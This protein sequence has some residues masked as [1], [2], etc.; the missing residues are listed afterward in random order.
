M[1]FG[2]R[3]PSE[4]VRAF[5]TRLPRIRHQSVWPRPGKIPCSDSTRS[6][7]AICNLHLLKVVEV[8]TP[9][10]SDLAAF[11]HRHFWRVSILSGGRYFRV[12]KTCIVHGPYEVA[13]KISRQL[14]KHAH[15][16]FGETSFML[17]LF[18]INIRQNQG[19][20]QNWLIT[21]WVFTAERL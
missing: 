3:G 21:V 17:L 19:S 5:S 8:G 4:E 10:L 18:K 20:W 11:F 15:F 7:L 1:R 2:S 12:A 13:I 6:D 9:L 14:W 16:L